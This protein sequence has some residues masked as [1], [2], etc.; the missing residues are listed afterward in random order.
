MTDAPATPEPTEARKGRA[1]LAGE[2]LSLDRGGDGFG[3]RLVKTVARFFRTVFSLIGTLFVIGFSL[4]PLSALLIALPAVAPNEAVLTDS[5]RPAR[6]RLART[7]RRAFALA[8]G[9]VVLI[10]LTAFAIEVVSRLP[11]PAGGQMGT[12]AKKVLGFAVTDFVPDDPQPAELP[13]G[14]TWL[15]TPEL[16]DKVRSLQ[17]A[18]NRQN[19]NPRDKKDASDKLAETEAE[20]EE[21]APKSPKLQLLRNPRLAPV[22]GV[23]LW[24]LLP[25]ALVEQWPFVLLVVYGTDLLLLLLIGKVPLAYNFR[26]LWVRR[27]DTALTAVAFTVVVALVVVLLAFVNGMYKLNETTGVPGNV[28]VMSE[29]ST[30]ELFSN[31]ARGGEIDNAMR[32]NLTADEKGRPIGGGK[33]V[34]VARG[35]FGPSGAFDR[36]PADAPRDLPGAT[37][38]HSYESYIVMNQAIPPKPG[39][40]PKRRFVQLRAF[41]D[42]RLG[43]A[44]H[45]IDLEPGGQW[46]SGTGVEPGSKAPDGREYL[47]CCIGEGAAATLGEDAGKARLAVG[48]TFELG[49]RWWKVVGLMRTRGTTYGSEV[50]AGIENPVV[51]ATG[52][53]DKY[54]TLVLRMADD[55]AASAR[56]MAYFLNEVYD[57]A[58]LKAF[59]EPDYYKEL[60]KTN[61]QFLTAIV[62]MAVIMAV[63]GIFGV[64]NTMFASIAA[65]IKEVGVL[66]ILG[67]KRW[68][69]L[70]SFMIESL[71]IAFA[72]GLLGCLL[73]LFANGFEAASTLSGGQGGGKSVTLTMQVDV[74][75]LATGMLFTLVMGRLGGLV[76]AL[77]AMRMEILDSLR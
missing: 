34:G 41:Q 7:F 64:M 50:W 43:G 9:F 17:Q 35:T 69:I 68:Q 27:R 59:S 56:A 75:I 47:Q 53:G 21:R 77:S 26:Y 52:K 65:R 51:R 76:P 11:L 62:M 42:V 63:G 4:L 18:A 10:A 14:K 20:L 40:T 36:L 5:I 25:L 8:A 45:N 71:A 44:V 33:G 22:L 73:G 60:T 39:E 61:E 23:P 70:I 6:S 46:V 48:D 74:P 72:G 57:Q 12:L 54:T 1:R 29:G 49:D 19:L 66:R 38:L 67:F 31:L 2:N 32:T 15:T 24:K 55:S 13:E 3:L 58:K 28:L 30:D 37:Y 16:L